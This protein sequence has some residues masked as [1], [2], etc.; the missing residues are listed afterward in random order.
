M[1]F[2]IFSSVAVVLTLLVTACSTDDNLLDTFEPIPMDGILVTSNITENTVWEC[3]QV[4][5]LGGRIYIE[6]QRIC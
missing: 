3:D 4:Y 1:N 2:R 6:E 5:I